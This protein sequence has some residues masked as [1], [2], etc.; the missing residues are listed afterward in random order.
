MVIRLS[1]LIPFS[2]SSASGG[3]GGGHG[4]AAN[5]RTKIL[6]L[7]PVNVKLELELLSSLS[8]T[9]ITFPVASPTANKRLR[10]T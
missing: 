2:L 4:E 8:A 5:N 10:R 1:S 7:F 6:L 3:G 9:M